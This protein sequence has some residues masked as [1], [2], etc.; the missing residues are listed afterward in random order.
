MCMYI[1]HKTNRIG[2]SKTQNCSWIP[3]KYSWP[4]Q[5]SFVLQ[6][7]IGNYDSFYE[8]G[9]VFSAAEVHLIGL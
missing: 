8:S 6:V 3:E 9:R 5:L 2:A 1:Q 4:F 7:E